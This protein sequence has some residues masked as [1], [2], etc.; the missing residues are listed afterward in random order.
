MKFLIQ[1]H[2]AVTHADLIASYDY[3]LTSPARGL[4]K[5]FFRKKPLRRVVQYFV[6]VSHAD[7]T[8]ATWTRSA[9]GIH[10]TLNS[11]LARDDSI[12]KHWFGTLDAELVNDFINREKMTKWHKSY[13]NS[14]HF[15]HRFWDVLHCS[16]TSH[17]TFVR[18]IDDEVLARKVYRR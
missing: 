7:G 9:D 1:T 10:Q 5:R 13:N 8:L 2:A 3:E 18:R 4:F 12:V 17:E 14:T 15:C 11:N 16:C 6:R